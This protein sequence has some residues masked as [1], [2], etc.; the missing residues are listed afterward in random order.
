LSRLQANALIGERLIEELLFLNE[1]ARARLRIERVELGAL[2]RELLAELRKADPQREVAIEVHEDL[3]ADADR[4]LAQVAL[5]HLLGNAW[6][7]SASRAA[8]RIEFGRQDGASDETVFYIRDNG[9][10]FDMNYADKLFH[11]FQPLHTDAALRGTGAGLVTVHRI[12]DRH[13]GRV[14]ADSRP[15]DGATFYFTLPAA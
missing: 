15:G 10:G 12:I 2:S 3:W 6:K 8:A 1:V 9:S 4:H 11:S 13:G 5:R 7:F 14:W